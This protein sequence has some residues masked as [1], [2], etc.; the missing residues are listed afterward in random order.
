MSSSSV[1]IMMVKRRLKN[2][3]EGEEKARE[4]GEE[5]EITE[6]ADPA[7]SHVTNDEGSIADEEDEADEE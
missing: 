1:V 3:N 2:V 5:K 4:D 7:H 6:V